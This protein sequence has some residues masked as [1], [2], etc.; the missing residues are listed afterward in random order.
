MAPVLVANTGFK[1]ISVMSGKSEISSD[2]CWISP[3][4]ASRST[5]SEPRTPFSISAAAMPSSIDS[6]SSR[7]AGASRKVMSFSTSTRMPPKPNA[8]S[9]PNEGSVTAPMMTSWPPASICCTCTPRS[10]ALASYFLA[11]AMMVAKPFSTSS[12]LFTPTSTPPASVLW[13]ISGDTILSTTGKPMADAIF[14]ASAAEVATPSFG[15]EMPYASHT[16][17]PS[18]AVSEVRPSAFTLSSIFLT[19]ALSCAICL[20]LIGCAAGCGA[21]ASLLLAVYCALVTA[22][23]ATARIDAPSDSA[24]AS[25]LRD[26]LRAVTELPQNLI[27]MLAKQWGTRYLGGTFRHLDRVANG[28]VLATLGMIDLDHGSRLPQRRLLGDLLHRQDR[29]AWDVVLVEQL[30]R[31]ELGL[32][33]GPLFDL[34]EDFHQVWES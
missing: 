2:T 22:V 15:T 12:T 9:L 19:A 16:S 26:L 29:A 28:Q 14:A 4:S 17:L 30:H 32:G 3:A 5:G 33:L 34:A 21:V 24:R 6:A 25:Q 8:T 13:R 31:L 20:P 11:L 18:G 7:V 10:F 23:L 1:S 27:G